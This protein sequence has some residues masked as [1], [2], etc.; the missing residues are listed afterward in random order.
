MGQESIYDIEKITSGKDPLQYYQEV[1]K[2]SK[3]GT[4][5]FFM[6]ITKDIKQL[7]ML[8]DI[9]KPFIVREEYLK[10]PAPDALGEYTMD[11][12]LRDI[13]DFKPL[14]SI[15]KDSGSLSIT[16]GVYDLMKE[17]LQGTVGASISYKVRAGKTK[18]GLGFR[19]KT[20]N[21]EEIKKVENRFG[22]KIRFAYYV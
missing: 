13:T 9:I 4:Y 16:H 1:A 6:A 5:Y 8:Q 18:L 22:I 14:I 7:E 12:E 20:L 17:I 15:F 3:D 19:N 10:I 11:G 21:E 2:S